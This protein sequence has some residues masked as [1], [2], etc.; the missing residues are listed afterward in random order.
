[1]NR[2]PNRLPWLYRA[3]TNAWHWPLFTT[4]T[5]ACGSI[6]LLV[7]FVDKSGRLQHKIAQQWARAVVWTSGC[8]LTIRGAENL[9]KQPVAQ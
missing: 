2:R 9:Y 5:A 4:I 3:R 8:K 7:S 1:M 6:A